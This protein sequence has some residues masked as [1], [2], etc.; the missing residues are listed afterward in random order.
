MG[1]D[2]APCDRDDMALFMAA[3]TVMTG[4]GA[5][6]SFWYSSWLGSGTLAQSFPTLFKRSRRKNMMVMEALIDGSWIKDLAHGRMQDLL[7]GFPAMHTRITVAN[8]VTTT[9]GVQDTIHWDT[10]ESG[11]YSAKSAYNMQFQG[12]RGALKL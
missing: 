5:T 3:T 12:G 11:L 2:E 7:I 10:E 4:N 6:T 8:T 1:G 9:E